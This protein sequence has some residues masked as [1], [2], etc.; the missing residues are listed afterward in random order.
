MIKHYQEQYL[1]VG[2]EQTLSSIRSRFWIPASRGLICSV[3]KHC[4]YCKRENT[5]MANIPLDRL[6]FNEKPFKKT[7]VDYSGPY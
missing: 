7:G 6:C 1:H 2:R 4:L 5:L 3:M